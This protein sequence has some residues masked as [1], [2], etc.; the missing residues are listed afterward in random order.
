M[1]KFLKESNQFFKIGFPM[2]GSQLSFMIMSATDTIVAGRA[3]AEQL[4]GLV[5]ANSFTYPLFMLMAG[6]I[7]SVIPIVAQLNGA[8]K[9]IEIGQKIREVFW[10][11]FL[12]GLLLFLIFYHGS[13]LLKFLPIDDDIV[14][15]SVSYLKHVI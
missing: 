12:L 15:I 1:N 13:E 8:N 2:L 3:G 11:A 4:A 14:S 10:I 5:I 9:N 7:F 6:I